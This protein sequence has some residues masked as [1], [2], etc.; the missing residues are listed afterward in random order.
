MNLHDYT[1]TFTVSQ[2]PEEAYGAISNV[3]DWWGKDVEGPT[4][5]LGAEFTFRGED[6]HYSRIRVTQL[7]PGAKVVWLVLDN[8]LTFVEDK[9]EW[10]GN[11]IVFE[12]SET[13]TGTQVCFTQHGLVPEYECFDVCSNAWTFFINDSLQSLITSGEGKPMPKWEGRP[14]AQSA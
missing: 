14:A 12:I 6:K 11:L 2:T 4:D 13:A 3:R 9:N 1:I 10:K 5:Q 8:S 7:V